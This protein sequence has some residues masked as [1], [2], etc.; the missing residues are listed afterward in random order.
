MWIKALILAI[1]LNQP[2]PYGQ[3][4]FGHI[5]DHMLITQ[6]Y[7]HVDIYHIYKNI[8]KTYYNSFSTYYIG[9]Q[10]KYVFYGSHDESGLKS[11]FI[12]LN[13]NGSTTTTFHR[14]SCYRKV[15]DPFVIENNNLFKYTFD[16]FIEFIPVNY[17]FE[18]DTVKIYIL[19]L[20]DNERRIMLGMTPRDV[21][22]P[23]QGILGFR[24]PD[25]ADN[26]RILPRT[27]MIRWSDFDKRTKAWYYIPITRIREL[28]NQHKKK[29]S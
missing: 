20:D 11:R 4:D 2:Q 26:K 1:A 7:D 10:A 17:I 12:R 21:L 29:E 27:R 28:V 6:K 24:H 14:N 9:K 19:T 23:L 15:I 3:Y 22:P 5:E 8:D 16:D 25:L 18:T 13:D